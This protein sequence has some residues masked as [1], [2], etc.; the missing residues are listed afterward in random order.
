MEEL[1]KVTSLKINFNE[2]FKDILEINLMI[3][4]PKS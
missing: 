3:G 1:A 2:I 4:V